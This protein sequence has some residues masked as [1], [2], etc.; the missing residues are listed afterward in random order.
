MKGFR[1]PVDK[2]NI[3]DF[4][5]SPIPDNKQIANNK[6]NENLLNS[7]YMIMNST[8]IS[9]IEKRNIP[10]GR[11][12][13]D[14]NPPSNNI[15]QAQVNKSNNS[16]KGGINLHK[17]E[18]EYSAKSIYRKLKFESKDLKDSLL[19]KDAGELSMNE[20]ITVRESLIKDIG[21]TNSIMNLKL[22]QHPSYDM[23]LTNPL[24]LSEKAHS[25]QI[26]PNHSQTQFANSSRTSHPKINFMPEV[27]S[28]KQKHEIIPIQEQIEMDDPHSLNQIHETEE[29]NMISERESNK[30][31]GTQGK[32]S[33][34]LE[35]INENIENYS[36][37]EETDESEDD[38]LASPSYKEKLKMYEEIKGRLKGNDESEYKQKL[39]QVKTHQPYL[40]IMQNRC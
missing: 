26:I 6:E 24:L 28:L 29:S 38:S 27:S 25:P 17:N 9:P 1:D 10:S 30:N 35:R 21:I 14:S 11:G 18:E 5:Q 16:E 19:E 7:P 2:K 15:T 8:A 22:G 33:L 12:I 23:S 34:F 36:K 4:Q 32:E 31:E 3:L 37:N 20:L 13:H 39:S 40:T